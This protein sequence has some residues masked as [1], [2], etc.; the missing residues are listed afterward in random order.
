VEIISADSRQ[1]YRGL[2]IGTAKVDAGTRAR[3][4][5]HGLD[6]VEPDQPFS[7]AEFV[8]H[9]TD[10]LAGIAARGAVAILVGGTGLYL[11]AVGRGLDVD[12][13]PTD[14]AL[15]SRLEADLAR[16]GLSTSAG[17]LRRMARELAATVDL[18]NPR[19]VVRALEIA[20]LAGDRPRPP[21]R[22]YPGRSLR[23]GLT[24]QDVTHRSWIEAR[25]RAQFDA[26][27]LAEAARLRQRHAPALPA[28]SAIGYREAWAVLDGSAT[29]EEAIGEDLR[30]NIAFARRQRTWFRSEPGI[31]WIDATADPLGRALERVA[32]FLASTEGSDP[33]PDPGRRS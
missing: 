7:A 10:A 24:V 13:L 20:E 16:D 31:E 25:A 22:G 29:L 2:D 23:L 4:R 12:A 17:R 11:R 5:H 26:G 19:R 8:A 6:L 27:L 30:R 28:F 18:N 15:R 3:I 33:G 32:P 14:A 1:V 21:L 9:A